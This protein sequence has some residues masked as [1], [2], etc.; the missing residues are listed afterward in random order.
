[1]KRSLTLTAVSY[2]FNVLVLGSPTTFAAVVTHDF[3]GVITSVT[4]TPNPAG[5][6]VGDTFT[7]F[8]NYDTTM[9]D[10]DPNPDVGTYAGE[11]PSFPTKFVHVGL[12]VRG[13]SYN[14]DPFT[15]TSLVLRNTAT[16]DALGAG[17]EVGGILGVV[18][19]NLA[20][21]SGEA[22]ADTTLPTL[23]SDFNIGDW[24]TGEIVFRHFPGINNGTGFTGRI[25][26]TKPRLT[27]FPAAE[28]CWASD[29]GR[30]YQV[31]WSTAAS[32]GSWSN[33]GGAVAGTGA[34]ICVFDSTRGGTTRFYRIQRTP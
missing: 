2:L 26:G 24:E 16:G 13:Q 15:Y 27:V 28:I 19:V 21:S 7:G 4:L 22:L 30:T 29:I 31:Q 18:F 12:T 11:P 1:M 8:F 14:A 9:L 33:L 5:I 20:D 23:A 25:F 34:E 6:Q 32:G 10:R 17:G 3:S